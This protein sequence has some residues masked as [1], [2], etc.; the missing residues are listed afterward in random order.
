[1]QCDLEPH[2]HKS[3]QEENFNEKFDVRTVA[4]LWMHVFWNVT[5]SRWLSGF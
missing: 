4:V 1:L 2:V 3:N 5:L